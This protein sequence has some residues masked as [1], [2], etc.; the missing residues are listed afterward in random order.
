MP[1][2]DVQVN[3]HDLRHPLGAIEYVEYLQE[4]TRKIL[5]QHNGID[6]MV[7][8][9][10]ITKDPITGVAY[11]HISLTVVTDSMLGLTDSG[12]DKQ[13]FSNLLKQLALKSEALMICIISEAW[14]IKAETEADML[15][16]RQWLVT[17]DSIEDCPLRQDS[18]TIQVEHKALDPRHQIWVA[19]IHTVEGKRI[20][21]EFSNQPGS[22]NGRFCN[23]LPD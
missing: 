12:Q 17:H 10:A 1:L 9:I 19:P 4:N 21:G 15:L 2:N 5:K 20:V 6:E 22:D 11:P 7:A 13:R 16:A 3:T 8:F 18:V 14:V 23:L